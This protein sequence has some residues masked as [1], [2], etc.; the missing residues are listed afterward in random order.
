MHNESLIGFFIGIGVTLIVF[1]ICREIIC[2]YWKIN[3][4]VELLERQNELLEK[5]LKSKD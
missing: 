4:I 3:K 1:L 2:W 5:N